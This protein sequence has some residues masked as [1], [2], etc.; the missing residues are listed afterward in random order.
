LRI[1]PDKRVVYLFGGLITAQLILLLIQM[2]KPRFGFE[3][4]SQYKIYQ[5]NKSVKSSQVQLFLK[6]KINHVLLGVMCN[7]FGEIESKCD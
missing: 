4:K 1:T 5:T 3:A 2:K 7:M 6:R